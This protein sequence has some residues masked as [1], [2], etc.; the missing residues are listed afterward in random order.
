[1]HIQKKIV[2]FVA[3]YIVANP[4]T[5]K[6]VRGILGNWVASADGLPTQAGLLLHAL[7]FVIVAHIMWK[8]FMTKKSGYMGKGQVGATC[9]KD[10][11]CMWACTAGKCT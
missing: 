6:A 11:D 3:F 9:T 10:S 8:L 2:P 7:V 1:M 5:F 4:M